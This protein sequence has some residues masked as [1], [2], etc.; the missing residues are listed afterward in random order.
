MHHDWLAVLEEEF[1]SGKI[2]SHLDFFH[3]H[4]DLLEDN[5]TDDNK[6]R[7]VQRAFQNLVKYKSIS[8]PNKEKKPAAEKI[9][10]EIIYENHV[11][12]IID[13]DWH[14]SDDTITFGL[15]GDT[16]LNS[17][18]T[19]I[20]YLHQFYDECKRCG[21]SE[22]Y[23]TGDIDDGEKMRPGHEYELYK[24]GANEHIAEI[25][26]VYPKIEGVKTYFITG[27]H[28][29]S[30]RK[31]CGL[32]IGEMIADKREDMIY[33]GRDVC[34]V[35][36]TPKISM[37]MRHPWDGTAYA[38]SYKPQKIIESM[39]ESD[40]PTIMGIGHYHKIEYLY[41]L[42]VHCLQTGCFQSAT[43]FTTGKGIRVSMGGWIITLK[44]N[45]DGTLKYILPRAVTYR[46]PIKDD[47]KNYLN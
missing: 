9:K 34:T 39:D 16:Q 19:Q 6:R 37:M 28:D 25:I 10:H 47:Y 1:K 17:K 40:R 7:K 32:D 36:I 15:M 8:N 29:A 14:N 22:I 12:N 20:T 13:T 2:Q 27:N 38:L 4:Y 46:K 11:E 23:H 24:L 26:R 33:L 18:Y 45:P 5:C 41:Y 35:N 30:F 31:L 3:N 42:G 44:L 43:P 21:V